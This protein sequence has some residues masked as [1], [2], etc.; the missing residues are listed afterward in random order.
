MAYTAAK[1]F[2]KYFI[3]NKNSGVTSTFFRDIQVIGS[4][5]IP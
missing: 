2:S 5:N 1:L 4:E 3:Y